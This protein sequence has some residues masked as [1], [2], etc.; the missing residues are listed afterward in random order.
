[1][2]RADVIVGTR[3]V[4]VRRGSVLHANEDQAAEGVRLR[5]DHLNDL[6]RDDPLVLHE[7]TLADLL[8]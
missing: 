4:L 6:G 7:T 1:V 2:T 3:K 8:R 5:R